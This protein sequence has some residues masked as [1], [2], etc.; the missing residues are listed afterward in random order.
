MTGR[1]R[2]DIQN[3]YVVNIIIQSQYGYVMVETKGNC[4]ETVAVWSGLGTK[5]TW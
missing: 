4:C 2:E 5:H 3:K 1:E